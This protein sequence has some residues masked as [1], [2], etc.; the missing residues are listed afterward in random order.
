VIAISSECRSAS[1]ESPLTY[2]QRRRNVRCARF[3]LKSRR[4]KLDGR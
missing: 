3:R 1:P 2:N 4:G